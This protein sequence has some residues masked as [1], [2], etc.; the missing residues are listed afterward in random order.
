MDN[1]GVAECLLFLVGLLLWE[2]GVVALY[3]GMG[4]DDV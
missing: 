3:L 2:F 4:W 1:I